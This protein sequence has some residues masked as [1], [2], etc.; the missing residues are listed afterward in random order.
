MSVLMGTE[1]DSQLELEAAAGFTKIVVGLEV[2]E[3]SFEATRQA[4]L[5]LEQNGLL[6]LIA[7]YQP[8][9]AVPAWGAYSI[10]YIEPELRKTLKQDAIKKLWMAE[11]VATRAKPG[12]L[13]QAKTK[14]EATAAALVDAAIEQGADLIAIG[15]PKSGR[16]WG[17]LSGQT[18]TFVLHRA[19]CSVLVARAPVISAFKRITV[20]IDGSPTSAR[21]LEVARTIAKQCKAELHVV[22]AY[23]GFELDLDA[24]EA[25]D[26][27]YTS[28]ANDPVDALLGFAGES[29]L[30]V[31]GSRG[32]K[33]LRS[34]GSVSERVAHEAV[35]SVLVVR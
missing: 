5:L 22:A 7:A 13:I 10:G 18:A 32:L 11:Q 2:D 4:S 8:L 19:P 12:E 1:T 17:I 16:L 31:V 21:A 3:S 35:C 20:G 25:L 28:S 27:A 14:D 6:T 29:D 15:A 24:V 23:G 34:L 33:G 26:P 30:L 9:A